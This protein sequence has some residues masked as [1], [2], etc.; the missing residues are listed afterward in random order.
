MRGIVGRLET[1][2]VDTA[3]NI[4]RSVGAQDLGA[5]GR[6]ASVAAPSSAARSSCRAGSRCWCWRCRPVRLRARDKLAVEIERCHVPGS[7][8]SL[9]CAP[10]IVICLIVV[11]P[12]AFREAHLDI[13]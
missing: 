6:P 11:A 9:G 12:V 7:I 10:G 5:A 2:P 1:I 4:L 3:N 8:A 13:A